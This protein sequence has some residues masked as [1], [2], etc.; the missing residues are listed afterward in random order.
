MEAD[1]PVNLKNNNGWNSLVEAISFGSRE[2]ITEML[3]ASRK[4]ARAQL[5]AQKPHLFKVLNEIRDF[6]IEFKWV[7]H[8]WSKFLRKDRKCVKNCYAFFVSL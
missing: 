8:S 6:S 2:I 4:Q 7:F 3:K 1:A 5:S